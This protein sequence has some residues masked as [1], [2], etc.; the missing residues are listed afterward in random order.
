MFL[1]NEFYHCTENQLIIISGKD[2]FDFI[3]GI[4]SNDIDF[5]KKKIAVYAAM[6]TPQGRFLYDFFISYFDDKFYL[7]CNK[8]KLKEIF[9]KLS[10]FK[11]KSKVS[12]EIDKQSNI[13]ITSHKNG[14]KIISEHPDIKYFYDPRFRKF[15]SRIYLSKKRIEFLKQAPFSQISK[16]I[17]NDLRLKNFIP[18]FIDDA[19]QGKS[20]LLEMRFDELNGISWKKGCYMGQEITARMKYRGLVKRKLFGVKIFFKT[21]LNDKIY[22]G[23]K[24]IGTLMTNNQKFGLAVIDLANEL[25]I[26]NKHVNCGDSLLEILEP[27]WIQNN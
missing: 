3:Q 19:I 5:L 16:K 18:D 17:Y 4:I 15:L 8:K 6:L 27:W 11:L 22:F 20:L 7:E 26:K 14:E 13:F 21:F 2:K 1:K 12:I 24:L 9:K 23:D 25:N 10:F